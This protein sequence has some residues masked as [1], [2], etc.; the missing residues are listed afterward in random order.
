MKFEFPQKSIE[1][2]IMAPKAYQQGNNY[3]E[4]KGFVTV[5]SKIPCLNVVYHNQGAKTTTCI[6]VELNMANKDP[7]SLKL[8]NAI[9]KKDLKA[10]NLRATTSPELRQTMSKASNAPLSVCPNQK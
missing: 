2:K 10:N 7:G 3:A 1:S 6:I 5:I 8:T 9:N 4:I